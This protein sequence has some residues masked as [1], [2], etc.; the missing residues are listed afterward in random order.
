LTGLDDQIENASE[1]EASDN[2]SILSDIDLN[3]FD[4][5]PDFEFNFP[6][7]NVCAAHTLQ[8]ALKDVFE[9]CQEL[10]ELNQV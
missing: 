9:N 2:D 7:N 10:K 8:L 3:D 6:K 1:T 5:E 4:D